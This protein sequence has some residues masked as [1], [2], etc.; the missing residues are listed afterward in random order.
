MKKELE[1]NI[2][3]E[4]KYFEKYLNIF[5]FRRPKTILRRRPE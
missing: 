2:R 1:E 3:P 4:K 5:F